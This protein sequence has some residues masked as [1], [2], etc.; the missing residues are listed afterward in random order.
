MSFVAL[1]IVT[2][3]SLFIGIGGVIKSNDK[4]HTK[5]HCEEVDR[6]KK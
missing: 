6:E 1:A 2:A 4:S 5:S 3:V